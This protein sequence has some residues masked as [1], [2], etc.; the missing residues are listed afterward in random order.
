MKR[1][2]PFHQELFMN[3]TPIAEVNTHR[4]LHLVFSSDCGWHT[5]IVTITGKGW[6][7]INILRSFKFRLDRKSLERMYISFIRPVIEYSGIVWDNCNNVNKQDAEKIQIE[8]L[9]IIT[10]ATKLCSIAK[11]CQETG[12]ETLEDRRNKRK[13]YNILQ[14]VQ[15]SFFYI[16]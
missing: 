6:Q 7:R 9:R 12:F 13:N 11:L 8:A 2:K 5:H 15:Q 14:N 3:N 4:H 1:N 10:G 16:S